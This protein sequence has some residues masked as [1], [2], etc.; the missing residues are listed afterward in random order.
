MK[1]D[2]KLTPP[3]PA[4]PSS[5]II[6]NRN[7]YIYSMTLFPP[8]NA[9]RINTFLMYLC[10]WQTCIHWWCS[11]TCIYLDNIW[12][13]NCFPGSDKIE[14]DEILWNHIYIYIQYRI[15][16]KYSYSEVATNPP[17]MTTTRFSWTSYIRFDRTATTIIIL[18]LISENLNYTHY[19][20]IYSSVY[21]YNQSDRSFHT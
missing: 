4:T 18:S 3:S 10:M 6:W 16:D 17:R 1:D 15:E 8:A 9:Y 5:F 7:L 11:A 12:N 13:N 19:I 2:E 14:R 21:T 20:I